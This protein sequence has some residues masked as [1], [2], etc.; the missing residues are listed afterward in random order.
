VPVIAIFTKF[1]AL[2]T[3]AFG[4]LRKQGVTRA[5]AKDKASVHAME[6]LKEDYIDQLYKSKYKPK[7]HVWL[8]GKCIFEFKM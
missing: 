8:R 4:E 6:K 1:D 7:K 2:I 3:T 5:D